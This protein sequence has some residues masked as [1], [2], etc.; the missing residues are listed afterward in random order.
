MIDFARL[1][2]IADEVDQLQAAQ[3]LGKFDPGR[4]PNIVFPTQPWLCTALDA[5]VSPD[6]SYRLIEAAIN[7][8]QSKL[9]VYVY[10]ISADYLIDLLTKAKERGVGIR[11]MYDA[12]GTRKDAQ[13]TLQGLGFPV[14]PA[15]SSGGRSVFTVC[16]QKFVVVDDRTVVVESANWAATSV[17]Q[18]EA[19]DPFKKGNR[20]WLVRIDQADAATFFTQVFD[21]DWDIPDLGAAAGLLARPEPTTDSVFLPAELVGTPQ[22]TFDI[23]RNPSANRVPVSPV[24]SPINYFD[25]VADLLESAKSSID[26]QQQYILAGDKVNDLLEIVD[27]KR[28]QDGVEVRIIVSAAFPKNWRATVDTLDAANLKDCLKA[29][30]LKF[31]THCHNKGVIVDRKTVIVSSTNWSANSITKAREA[32]VIMPNADMASYYAGVFD[33]DWKEGIA[34][35]DVRKRLVEVR[36]DQM[37]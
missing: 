4:Q 19:G 18:I 29:L 5:A 1:K 30:S 13:E 12:G 20:E 2:R 37:I 17:P 28:T 27:R 16:H 25:A 22:K 26:I 32:G 31:F 34:A 33:E 8:S 10:E 23:H 3:G 15:P 6:C 36:L 11:L 7:E 35:D 14:K 24:L 21:K 9:L